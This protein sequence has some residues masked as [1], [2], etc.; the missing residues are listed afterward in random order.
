MKVAAASAIAYVGG[1]WAR[2]IGSG[3]LSS[4]AAA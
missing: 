3:G 1:E 2:V 4:V